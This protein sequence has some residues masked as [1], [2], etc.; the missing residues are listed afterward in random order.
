MWQTWGGHGG[1][2]LQFALRFSLRGGV[3]FFVSR[4]K[5]E[6]HSTVPATCRKRLSV[7][8]ESNCCYARLVLCKSGP[9]LARVRIPESYSFVFAAGS[10]RFT[11]GR[12]GY[13][14]NLE[15]MPGK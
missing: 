6:L 10:Y 3:H 1:P 13:G 12:K 2:P 8:R 15:L 14:P 7:W 11:I 9:F 4:S 5:P